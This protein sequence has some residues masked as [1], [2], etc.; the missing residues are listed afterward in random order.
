MLGVN[1]IIWS[2]AMYYSCTV[3]YHVIRCCGYAYWISRDP[4]C[5]NIICWG[6]LVLWRHHMIRN[7]EASN[8]H[9]CEISYDPSLR[10]YF[11]V[12]HEPSLW[13]IPWVIILRYHMIDC[14]WGITWTI[15]VR[16]SIIEHDRYLLMD[17]LIWYH[18]SWHFSWSCDPISDS[19]LYDLKI[20]IDYLP[21]K[22]G[23]LGLVHITLNIRNR[24]PSMD[25]AIWNCKRW[26]HF[27]LVGHVIQFDIA[28]V[29]TISS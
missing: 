16:E 5:V 1:G 10:Y 26:F 4:V 18:S 15:A 7:C 25:C 28:D 27:K 17:C 11:Q 19:W 29:E 13:G 22:C 23:S 24:F 14:L 9:C 8:G 2:L 12:C 21:L 6:K 20:S 3:G